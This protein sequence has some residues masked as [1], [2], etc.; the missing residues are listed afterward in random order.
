MM[1][2]GE[3]GKACGSHLSQV[4]SKVGATIPGSSLLRCHGVV[5]WDPC[6]RPLQQAKTEP[7]KPVMA[8]LDLE[9]PVELLLVCLKYTRS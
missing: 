7:S 1:P 4:T 2:A 6:K 9:V 8:R 5:R 3:L